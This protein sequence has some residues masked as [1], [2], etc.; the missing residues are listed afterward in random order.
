MISEQ[1]V[2][3]DFP[4]PPGVFLSLERFVNFVSGYVATEYDSAVI[5]WKEKVAYDLL[6]PTSV[7][8]NMGAQE[9]TTW[10]PGGIQTFPAAQFEAY[11][12]VMPHAEYVSGSACLF[13][14]VEDYIVGYMHA[15]DLDPT[16]PVQ[17]L[18]FVA[19][20]SSV[21]PGVVP[22]EDTT[23]EYPSVEEMAFAGSQSRLN[24]GMH[25]DES[26]PNAKVLC[27]GIGNYV[28]HG[29]V[30]LFNMEPHW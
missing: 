15:M 13:Q 7:I 26:V 24:G 5:S 23:L 29:T 8:K 3:P 1:F 18:P 11:K 9:I 10:A 19:G 30:G 4:T 12:R 20:S 14:G 2:D 6:R 28:L 17:F 25:F 22:A 27:K 16:F 21:E